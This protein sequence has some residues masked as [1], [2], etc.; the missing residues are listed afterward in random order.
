M[1]HNII[2]AASKEWNQELFL[3]FN[4]LNFCNAT[5]ISVRDDLNYDSLSEINPS[6]IFFVHWSWKIPSKIYKNFN[7]I[8]FHMTDLPY[9]RG[10]SPLQ[11]LILKGHTESMVSAI[12]VVEEIDA[13]PI[14]L[15]RKFDLIGS[16]SQI[17]KKVSVIIFFDM[18]P[19]IL[20]NKPVAVPQYGVIE[21]FDRR[22]PAQS[23][24]NQDLIE[25][26]NINQLYDFIR[27]LDAPGYPKAF[28]DFACYKMIFESVNLNDDVILGSVRI[29][30]K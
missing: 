17:Y 16:A 11:N 14:Y 26:L 4:K 5:L 3:E 25:S 21:Y 24:M 29:E 27:M 13:G 7:C 6:I 18:I 10:G 20:N 8:L 2:I 19:F 1:N 30:K 12:K 22:S 15:K 9:G 23:E 28:I